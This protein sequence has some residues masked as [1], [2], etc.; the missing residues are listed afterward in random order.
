MS[1]VP[2]PAQVAVLIPAAGEGQRLGLGPKAWLPLAGRPIVDW[3]VDKARQLAGEVLVGCPAGQPEPAGSV[4]VEGGATRQDTVQRLVEASTAPWLLVWDAT[5]PFA[6]CTLA[7]R[8]LA[9]AAATG[10]ATPY[11]S[12]EVPWLSVAQDRVDGTLPAGSGGT[13]QAPQAFRA[14]LLREVLG[15]AAQAGWHVQTTVELVLRAGH[16]VA[17]VPGEKLNLKLTTPE[18][19]QLA[20]ALLDRMSR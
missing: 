2:D 20:G 1:N 3:L 7:R 5:R 12:S 9:A 10:A 8:V 18:D 17:A 11:L 4:R 6:S 16:P 19:W 13:T 14:D 15:V